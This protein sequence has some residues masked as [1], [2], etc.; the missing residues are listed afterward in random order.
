MDDLRVELRTRNNRLWHLIFD[1]GVNVAEFC[2]MHGHGG[3]SEV[4]RFLNLSKSPYSSKGVRPLAQRIADDAQMLV[5]DLFPQDLYD[6]LIPQ[7]LVAEIPSRAYRGLAAAKRLALPPSQD[8]VVLLRELRGSMMAEA[9]KTLTPR[10]QMIIRRRFG[11]D[12]ESEWTLDDL[13]FVEG[14]G[15]ER[16]RQIEMKALRKLRHPSRAKYLRSYITPQDDMPDD[17]ETADGDV[18]DVVAS[19]RDEPTEM[20][21]PVYLSEEARAVLEEGRALLERLGVKTE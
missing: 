17:D 21:P 6:G 7:R 14:V 1:A 16:I 18:V 9:I 4:G 19:N 10:E 5:E 12:D 8:D 2:R 11:F 13:A 20:A 15:K 3:S